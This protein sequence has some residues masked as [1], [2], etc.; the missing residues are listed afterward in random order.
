[1]YKY[2]V[3]IRPEKLKAGWDRDRVMGMINEEGV[4]CFSGGCSEIY[5]ERAFT[6]SELSR[7]DRLPVARELGETS[8]MFLVHPT[9][10]QD[11][12]VETGSVIRKSISEAS[13][14]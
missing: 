9:L 3:F 2:Y 13:K 1:Y 12:V 6:A 11:R 10:S 14:P 4:P 5:L 7:K 8:L